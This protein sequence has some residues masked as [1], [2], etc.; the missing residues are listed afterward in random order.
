[1]AHAPQVKEKAEMPRLKGRFAAV[2]GVVLL[3]G[4]ASV[5][6]RGAPPP[7]Q[8]RPPMSEAPPPVSNELPQDVGRHRVALLVP[9]T[10]PN[11]GLGIAIANAA[12]MAIIQTNSTRLRI[13][14]Y[15]TGHGAGAAAEKALRE[16]N[17]L[18]LGPLLGADVR[19]VAP[20]A[21]A[22]HV[23][24][25]SFTNDSTVAGNGVW[26]M[27]FLPQQSVDRVVHYAHDHGV[28]RFA[29]LMPNG[30]YGERA[31]AA[32]LKTARS[33][34]WPVVSMQTYAAA[35][36]SM[37][38]AVSRLTKA[39]AFDGVMIAD[40]ARESTMIGPWVKRSSNAH[41]LGT[42]LW[43]D[44]SISASPSLVGAWYASV[45]DGLFDQ[46]V[47]SYRTQFGKSPP[48]IASL[49]YDAVLLA[50][51]I[52]NDW[53]S[54]QPFPVGK[55]VDKGGFAGLDGAF[56]FMRD[57]LSERALQVNQVTTAG[58]RIVSPAP[59]SLGG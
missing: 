31:G 22:A 40:S 49:G 52:S 29:G 30:I 3:A 7:V 53:R 59:Q 36:A 18:I 47:A 43:N 4:C 45:A 9:A 51:R 37:S 6:P 21:R 13:T 8:P 26:V 57:G 32:L 20:L 50:T 58:V 42:E 10:G 33:E 17:E 44:R 46:W 15:D 38:G 2:A 56:R 54:N 19:A 5:V 55:L 27:G 23:P 16:G 25:I 35:P 11:A 14:T 34:G 24:V 12:T 28:N 1:M 39:G 48:R 41:I